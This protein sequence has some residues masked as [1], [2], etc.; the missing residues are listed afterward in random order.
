MPIVEVPGLG[1]I[2]FPEGTPKEQMEAAIK[3]ALVRRGP[4]TAPMPSGPEEFGELPPAP[5]EA[6]PDIIGRAKAFL[7][8]E[9][10]PGA[11]SLFGETEAPGQ[12]V[13]AAGR[14]LLPESLLG[15]GAEAFGF[16]LA[17]KGLKALTKTATLRTGRVAKTLGREPELLK[18]AALS[19]KAVSDAFRAA[20]K[21]KGTVPT[22]RISQTLDEAVLEPIDDVAKGFLQKLRSSDLLGNTQAAQFKDVVRFSQDLQKQMK[23]VKDPQSR[24]VLRK[25]RNALVDE[26]AKVNPAL[27]TANVTAAR[28]AASQDVLKAI[29]GTKTAADALRRFDAVLARDKTLPGRLGIDE[30]GLSLLR[31]AVGSGATADAIKALLSRIAGPLAVGGAIGA[32]IGLF[33]MAGE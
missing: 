18:R 5:P 27:K 17:G 31:G 1:N 33:R 21:I 25:V 28:F 29:S 12:L 10:A 16:G 6:Q 32:G 11:K 24:A 9:P 7:T 14:L 15:L 23:F 4:N 13:R 20:E 22:A 2:E 3:D 26:S 30:K 8:R 19:D